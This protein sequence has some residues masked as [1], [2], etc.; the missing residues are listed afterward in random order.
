VWSIDNRVKYLIMKWPLMAAF[1]NQEGAMEIAGELDR[2][3]P[4]SSPD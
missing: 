2:I 4:L 3:A 1:D